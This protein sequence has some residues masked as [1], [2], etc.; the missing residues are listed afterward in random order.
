MLHSCLQL[1]VSSIIF[2]LYERLRRCKLPRRPPASLG[3]LGEYDGNV[4]GGAMLGAGMAF[5]GACPGTVLVQ[6]GTGIPSGKSAFVGGLLGGVLYAFSR[7]GEVP[8]KNDSDK[9]AIS[10]S[11]PERFG[12]SMTTAIMVFEGMCI[13]MIIAAKY[14]APSSD[15]PL[16]DPIIGGLLIGFAQLGT[17][18]LTRAPVGVSTAYEDIGK[19]FWRAITWNVSDTKGGNL[20]FTRAVCFASGILASVYTL[21][22]VAPQLIM[23]DALP[24]SP[25]RSVLGGAI[26][27]FGARLA[28][29]CTSG[30]GISGMSML[31][32]SSI[33]TVASMFAGGIG[34][35]SLL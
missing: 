8:H 7:R 29:G 12:I 20:L 35:A 27:V 21:S 22:S 19:W 2:A 24:I 31:G 10:V 6:L 16:L 32:V 13:A 28:G 17:L 9:A 33:I 30:H 4:L 25:L 14:L 11:L 15:R 5:T 1:T 34:L 18:I 23:E 3:L 26:M